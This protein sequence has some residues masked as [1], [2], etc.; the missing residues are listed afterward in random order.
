MDNDLFP[1]YKPEPPFMEYSGGYG[2]MGVLLQ[3]KETGKIQC[4]LCGRMF[5]NVARHV[6]HAHDIDD[7][8]YKDEVGL[9]KH[10]P[11]VC[12]STS[13]KL[14]ESFTSL[15]PE[16]KEKRIRLL[17]RNNK[18]L[19]TENR[20]VKRSKGVSVQ[21]Q[22]QYGTC[23]LQAKHAFWKEYTALGHVPTNNEMSGRLKSLVYTRFKSY[24]EALRAWGIGEEEL[25]SYKTYSR[26]KTKIARAK[27]NFF[28]KYEKEV[29]D[30]QYREFYHQN[31]RLPTWT[32]A[33]RLGFP[34]RTVFKRLYGTYDKKELEKLMTTH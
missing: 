28:P 13:Q 30:K 1:L 12:E 16:K 19:H 11:L 27:S 33:R 3:S 9:N 25:L 31:K 10:V 24:D 14:R 23:D 20:Y 4:H 26:G 8:G 18:R 6:Q 22:N 17:T 2:F 29:V 5:K 7:G 34:C 32:E 15:S 21:Y